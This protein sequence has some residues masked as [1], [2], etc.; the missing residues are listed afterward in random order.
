VWPYVQQW[1]LNLQHQFFGN[2]AVTAAYVGSKGTHLT[3]IRD[4]N[5]LH[6]VPSSANP[7]QAGQ[8]I[9]AANCAAG[10]PVNGT[11]A[12]G[13]ALTNLE[14]ACGANSTPFRPYLGYTDI[15][16]IEHNANSTY[17]AFQLSARRQF[18]GLDLSLAYTWSHSIDNS[19]DRYDGSLLNSY[20]L[21]GNK[22]SSNF[23]QTHV[24]N[25]SWVY[26]L[27]IF[28][29]NGILGGW[30]WSG[31]MSA[32]TG[33]P[34]T[35]TNG[36]FG[37]SA[38]VANGSGTGSRPDVV[39][40]PNGSPTAVPAPSGTIVGPLLYNP[41]AFA[42]PQ[43]LT[44]GTEGRNFLRNPGRWNF[45]MGLFKTFKI[46]ERQD[47]QFRAEGFNVFNHTQFS[48]VNSGAGCYVSSDPTCSSNFLRPSGAH[49]GRILQF[50]LKYEF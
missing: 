37:D 39:G 21:A 44:F 1:N 24:L 16:F 35:V 47:I 2:T 29:H 10:Y 32:Q 23:D 40:D 49:L 34:F 8:P 20:D 36:V 43:G 31:I 18:G 33:T 42:Q 17:H 7:F 4:L 6:P 45:D 15:N 38:G 46:T 41:G 48:G 3:D 22:G 30:Q 11:P 50:G 13:Q 25:M 28:Q 14:V 26:N 12:T 5:Q 19:S 27:S 9:T